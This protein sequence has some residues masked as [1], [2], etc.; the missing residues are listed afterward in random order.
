M[1]R[2][3]GWRNSEASAGR[4]E[5][6]RVCLIVP[7]YNEAGR[8]NL[9]AFRDFVARTENIDFIFVNDGSSDSTG[10]MLAELRQGLEHRVEI[11]VCEQ[12]GGKAEAVRVGALRALSSLRYGAFGYWDADLATP[13]DSIPRLLKVL[14]DYPHVDLVF[15]SRVKLCGRHIKRKPMRHY[16]GRVFATMVSTMLNLAIYDTQC[17][18]KL[19]R[20]T[21][22]II[23]VFELSFLSR[24]VFDVEILARL[25]RGADAPQLET[26]IYEY[27]L[28]VW[29]DISGSKLRPTDF[30]RAI[31]DIARIKRTYL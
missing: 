17:G 31:V 9:K 3:G 21:D 24:W 25:L 18:A 11:I 30:F 29:E 4:P 7:C 14:E 6:V 5:T 20:I 2:L 15:G 22:G 8:L 28:E 12:N 16:L 27:P 13:L 26:K 10:V 23:P 1:V 19:F